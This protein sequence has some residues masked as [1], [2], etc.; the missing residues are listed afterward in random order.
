MIAKKYIPELGDVVSLDFIP[1]D[2]GQNLNEAKDFPQA[3]EI[4]PR[5]RLAVVLSPLSYNKAS[6]LCVCVPITSQI[7]D[8]PFEVPI[9][10]KQKMMILSDQ[11]KS[12]DFAQ[13]NARLIAKVHISKIYQIK[14]LLASLL[15]LQFALN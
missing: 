12:I 5:Q 6:G 2:E 8:Y 4:K 9:T 15:G 3:H 11:I 7:R 10:L 14:K 1:N 13:R